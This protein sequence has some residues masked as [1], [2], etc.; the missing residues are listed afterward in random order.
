MS[1]SAMTNPAIAAGVGQDRE[2]EADEAVRA[3]LQRDRRE[4]HRPAGRRLDVGVRQPGVHRPH[5]HFNGKGDEE[6][7]EQQ[8]LRLERQRQ[9]IPLENGETAPA[10]GVQVDQRHQHQHRPEEGVEKELQRGVDAVRPAPD[11]DNEIHRDQH[12]LEEDVEQHAVEGGEHAVD[13]PG[14]DEECRHVL[15]HAP[16]DDDPARPDREHGDEA[17]EKDE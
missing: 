2:D 17:V 10:H 16:L 1:D 7:H 3:D 15:R 6:C 4:H 8:H 5:R 13:E 12:R 14:L 9:L 11:A